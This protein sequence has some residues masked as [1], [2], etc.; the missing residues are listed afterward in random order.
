[1]NKVKTKG[2]SFVLSLSDYNKNMEKLT[3]FRFQEKLCW[4]LWHMLLPMNIWIFVSSIVRNFLIWFNFWKFYWSIFDLQCC[5]NFYCTA[6]WL[7]DTHTHIY[8]IFH[9][10]FS[11]DIEYSSLCYPVGPCCLSSKQLYTCVTLLKIA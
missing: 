4:P 2:K 11:W 5:V 3:D 8:I 10:G 9:Y 1:M 7:H 6:Q